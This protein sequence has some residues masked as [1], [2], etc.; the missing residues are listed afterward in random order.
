M[1]GNTPKFFLNACLYGADGLILD[2][3][4][5]V[6]P[7]EKDA[8]LIL[9]RNALRAMEFRSSIRIVRLVAGPLGLSQA[10]QLR[11]HGVQAFILPKVETA[12]HIRELDEALEGSVPI[13]ALIETAKGVANSQEIAHASPRL[14]GLSLGVEDNLSDLGASR[15]EGGAECV[16]AFSQVINA[17]RAAGIQALGPV[18]SNVDDLEGL[19]TTI[20]RLAGLG[21]DG[22]SCI[23]PSQIRVIHAA[24]QPSDDAIQRA[25]EVLAA[26]RVGLE[27]GLGAVAVHGKMVDAPIAAQAR[28]TLQKAGRSE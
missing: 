24:L 20:R 28:R 18:F 21:F 3:E 6:A 8:A 16:W 22:F 2:L 1:P 4:D 26:Y 27:Q 15:S 10:T 11:P 25:V 7:N 12:E 23:H 17:A 19:S 9:V 13:I 5:S 14:I